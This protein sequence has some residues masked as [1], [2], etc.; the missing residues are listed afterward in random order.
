MKLNCLMSYKAP[1]DVLTVPVSQFQPLP[2][3]PHFNIRISKNYLGGYY[4]QNTNNP[5]KKK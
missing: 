4:M 2:S 1:N 3:F 5:Y